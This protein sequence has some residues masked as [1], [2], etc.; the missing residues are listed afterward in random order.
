MIDIAVKLE[1]KDA[2]VIPRFCVRYEAICESWL[3]DK[4]PAK[5]CGAGASAEATTED[6]EQMDHRASLISN[7]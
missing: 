4:D 3:D 1:V 2:L 5:V 6:L 7:M